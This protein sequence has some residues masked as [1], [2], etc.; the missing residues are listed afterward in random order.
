MHDKQHSQI[1]KPNPNPN[2][3]VERVKKQYLKED[4][5]EDGGADAPRSTGFV[6]YIYLEV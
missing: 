1:N 3:E 6:D 4:T 2:L 5:V